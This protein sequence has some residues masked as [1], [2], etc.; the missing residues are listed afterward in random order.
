MGMNK[1][2]FSWKENEIYN[3]SL[4]LTELKIAFRNMDIY[5]LKVFHDE[6]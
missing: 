3:A 6:F 5:I 2:V 1:S 4:N